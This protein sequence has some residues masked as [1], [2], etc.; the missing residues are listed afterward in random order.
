M[1]EHTQ[2]PVRPHYIDLGT[3]GT[4]SHEVAILQYGPRA[5]LATLPSSLSSSREHLS[6]KAI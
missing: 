2:A 3:L 5:V 1:A 4:W 6:G